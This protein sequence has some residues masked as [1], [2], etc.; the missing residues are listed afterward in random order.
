MDDKCKSAYTSR[1]VFRLQNN[2]G[3]LQP[4]E[5][6]QFL[7]IPRYILNGP[8]PLDIPDSTTTSSILSNTGHKE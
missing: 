3:M 1:M 2:E 4:R 6:R 7:P 5:G 8:V